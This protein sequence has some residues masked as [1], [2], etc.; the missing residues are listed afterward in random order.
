[1]SSFTAPVASDALLETLQ[2]AAAA[3]DADAV[4]IALLGRA[5]E[6]T[7]FAGG[8]I[9]QP[10]NITETQFTV[11]AIVNGHPARSACGTLDGLASA[12]SRA[13]VLARELAARAASP[14]HAAVA[15]AGLAAASSPD[16]SVW[17]EETEAFDAGARA[18]LAASAMRQNAGAA[19]MFG[20]AVTQMAVV[21]SAGVARHTLATEASGSLTA[22]VDE[23]TSH[24]IDLHRSA[25]A[26]GVEQAIE[27]TVREATAGRGRG[28]LADGHYTV[29]LG[30]QAAGELIGFL[31]DFGFAG[32]L[33]AAGVGLLATPG[34]GTPVAAPMVTVAD[35]ATAAAG[36]PIGFDL[37]GTPKSR[38]ALLD[39]GRVGA[40]VTDLTTAR[41]LGTASTGHAHVAREE[42]PRPVAANLRLEPGDQTEAELIAGVERG[43]YVQRFWYTRL[44]DRVTGTI[45][46]VSRDGCFLIENGRLGAPV[47]GARFTHSVLDLLST[48]DGLGRDLRSQP[49]MNVWNGAATAPALRGH[50]FR[51]GAAR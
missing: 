13:A 45:T 8:R 2:K 28:P 21:N 37:E 31:P 50:N 38:V 18:S 24:W 22:T 17:Y 7:R 41:A 23:G 4:E 35:D 42:P 33:A 25:S 19:G 20:R 5:G 10:Q 12:V 47:A 15:S 29:V 9:H 27:R 14:G 30:P 48:V 11:R 1:M 16:S 43:V 3:A 51:F 46:G 32:E 6:Y 44:V 34:P 26:L 39:A 36:L 40:A 49:V